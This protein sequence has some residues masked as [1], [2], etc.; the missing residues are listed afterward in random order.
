MSNKDQKLKGRVALVTGAT[1]GIGRATAIALAEEGADLIICARNKEVLS[2]FPE[3]LKKFGNKVYTYALDLRNVGEI[4]RMFKELIYPLD[5]LDI[6]INNVGGAKVGHFGKF[7]DITDDMWLDSFKFNFM[8]AVWSTKLSLPLLKKS[9][10]PRIVNV[11][12]VAGRQPGLWNP[13]YGAMKAALIHLTKSLSNSYGKDNILVNCVCPSTIHGGVWEENVKDRAERDSISFEEAESRV[14]KEVK[15]KLVL[16]Y[17]GRE[18]DVSGV[19]KFLCL[20]ENNF[21]TGDCVN[22]DG[23]QTKAIF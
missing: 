15:A 16:S 10:A 2:T 17:M 13:H 3:E 5:E 23:G 21:I 7:E 20:P 12:S 19:I 8:S 14:I 6:L 9:N 22:V 18:E 11:S 4:E 1:R